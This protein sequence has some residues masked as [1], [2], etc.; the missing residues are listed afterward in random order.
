M[1]RLPTPSA[2][3][4]CRHAGTAALITILVVCHTASLH[5]S[6]QDVKFTQSAQNVDTY[7]FVEITLN[8]KSPHAE[9]PFV[10]AA[11]EGWFAAEDGRKV[12]VDGFCD[13]SDGSI[14]RIRF[15][16]PEPGNYRYLVTYRQS[17]YERIHSGEFSAKDS[18]RRGLVRVD[19][20]PSQPVLAITSTVMAKTTF[21]TTD[22]FSFPASAGP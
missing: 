21:V 11:V 18:R 2:F 3:R 7:D 15:M 22:P 14:F 6:P 20:R 4:H 16:P 5:G 10:D 9:N 12:H 17:S 8:A 1:N 13:S 19:I